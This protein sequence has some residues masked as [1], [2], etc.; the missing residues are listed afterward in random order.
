MSWQSAREIAASTATKYLLKH[1][2]LL[3][4]IWTVD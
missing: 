1:V 3:P 2:A 4:K